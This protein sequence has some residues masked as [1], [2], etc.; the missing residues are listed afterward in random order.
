MAPKKAK[1]APKAAK[2]APKA[3]AKK[4]AEKRKAGDD[5]AP[6]AKKAK[7][8]AVPRP[9]VD[10]HFGGGGGEVYQEDGINWAVMLNQTNI[11]ANNNKFYVIQ[12]IQQ[13]GGKYVGF[14]RWGRV[15][16]PGQQAA[17][18]FPNVD[19]A[20]GVFKGKFKDKTKNDWEKVKDNHSA[21][22][23]APGKYDLVE[24][25]IEEDAPAEAPAAKKA[26]GGGGAQKA[27]TLDKQLQ[28]MLQTVFDKDMFKDQMKQ[29]KL[30]PAKTPL[31][32]LTKTQVQRGYEALEKIEEAVQKGKTKEL[33]RLCS[34]F[35][36]HIPHSFGRS[37]PPL[38]K[39]AAE[40]QEKYDLLNVLSD[41]EV[42]QQMDKAADAAS[43]VHPLDAQYKELG[44]TLTYVDPKSA[45]FKWIEAYTNNTKGGWRTPK[46]K[47][48]FRVD[49]PQD[50]ER[51]NKFKKL[52]NRRL[53]WHGTNV[54]VVAAILKTGLRIMPHSG[55]R[56]GA[57]I[58]FAS[59]NGKSA[60]YTRTDQNN[61]GFM[62]L[63]EV[64]LGKQ[65]DIDRDDHTLNKK[66][67]TGYGVDSIV[68]KGRTEPEPKKDIKIKGE[69][70]DIAVPQ[71]K[72]A[73]QKEWSKSSFSQTEYLVYDEGQVR[74]KYC[75]MMKFS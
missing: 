52:D 37:V 16:E 1:P 47:H 61:H 26:K 46:I 59:E 31:G 71:G 62:F 25:A 39:T 60:G 73:A 19:G 49:R 58:Y 8:G 23:S 68:A 3:S 27:C 51:M 69:W 33:D 4:G 29:M 53:L 20:K 72:P 6:A 32:K 17:Q 54:A 40:I 2:P 9:K 12:V 66:K 36:T 44:T 42:A 28:E 55:G 67:V 22:V 30:D 50:K 41:I 75:L 34:T 7:G 56:V 14:T 63:N 38:I 13:P 64:A 18:V 65:K 15:G 10:E 11:G 70:G 35:Y 57:G 74:I 24:T 45:E 5:A 43:S 21:F 48:A